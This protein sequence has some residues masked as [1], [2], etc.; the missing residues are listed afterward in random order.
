MSTVVS[1]LS[2]YVECFD[3]AGRYLGR[4]DLVWCPRSGDARQAELLD[5]IAA[6]QGS[7]ASL[8]EYM[9]SC[10]ANDV[11][12]VNQWLQD[13]GFTIQLSGPLDHTDFAVVA[14][15]RLALTWKHSGH[16]VNVTDDDSRVYKG[17]RLQN[18]FRI[19]KFGDGS[20]AT[21]ETNNAFNVQLVMI[22]EEAGPRGEIDLMNRV[23]RI[24]SSLT[25]AIDVTDD[26]PAVDVPNVNI[27]QTPENCGLVGMH[28]AGG[29][30]VVTQALVQYKLDMNKH[31]VKAEG[32]AAMAMARSASPLAFGQP[33][34]VIITDQAERSVFAAY[35]DRDSW[36][37]VQES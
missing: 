16:D 6:A 1:C 17:F 19:S 26:Y 24:L 13:R 8:S 29:E 10:A 30:A 21:L 27:D 12:V 18:G 20:A 7:R 37:P 5:L 33:F 3:A 22:N 34:Y 36:T 2:V 25:Q 28:T 11:A 9:A 23:R 14:A 4:D 35:V 31:G 32:A 15:F